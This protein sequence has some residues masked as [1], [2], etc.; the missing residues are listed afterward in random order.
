M[1]WR[2][3]EE[4]NK[5]F[6]SIR[7]RGDGYGWWQRT[8]HVGAARSKSGRR[9]TMHVGVAQSESGHRQ[10]DG[11]KRSGKVTVQA[12]KNHLNLFSGF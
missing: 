2:A 1:R 10:S 11:D 3:C 6:A 9:R 5:N 7:A 8:V 12:K 4:V